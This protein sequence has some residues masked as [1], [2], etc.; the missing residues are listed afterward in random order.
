MYDIVSY[1]TDIK[2]NRCGYYSAAYST[3]PHELDHTACVVGDDYNKYVC[4]FGRKSATYHAAL[5]Q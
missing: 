2:C 1:Y 5:H 3:H 4:G